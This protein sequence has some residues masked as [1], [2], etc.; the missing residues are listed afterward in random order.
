M[1]KLDELATKDQAVN[2]IYY[3]PPTL[4]SF[5]S[6]EGMEIGGSTVVV[7][8]GTGRNLYMVPELKRMQM[9]GK[10]YKDLEGN[11]QIED[12]IAMDEKDIES[13]GDLE[14][15]IQKAFISIRRNNQIFLGIMEIEGNGF[16]K[17]VFEE[18]ELPWEE[19]E[20][21]M[22]INIKRRMIIKYPEISKENWIE[23]RYYGKQK[24]FLA[25]NI[26]QGTLE[27]AE[28]TVKDPRYSQG[29]LIGIVCVDEEATYFFILGDNFDHLNE[30]NYKM[31]VDRITLEKMHDLIDKSQ[32]TP[33]SW[34]KLKF[35]FAGLEML[36]ATSS[37]HTTTKD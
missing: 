36:F 18:F 35:G 28:E 32:L 25:N 37:Q 33:V 30:S 5:A 12:F 7:S 31:P 19:I 34:W 15:I 4:I 16:E 1:S 23:I 14:N 29:I 3:P 17:N 24:D 27:I 13:S 9:W 10:F 8:T 26:R 6:Q 21:L 2:R 22:Q 11:P 20:K